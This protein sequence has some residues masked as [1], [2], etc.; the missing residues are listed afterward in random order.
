VNASLHHVLHEAV[1]EGDLHLLLLSL[2]L[3]A[4]HI[5]GGIHEGDVV[6]EVYDGLRLGDIFN[7]DVEVI[8]C[9]L[10]DVLGEGFEVLHGF[11]LFAAE[12]VLIEGSLQLFIECV[13]ILTFI[14]V[15]ILDLI[16]YLEADP[17]V[18]LLQFVLLSLLVVDL[19]LTLQQV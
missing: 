2:A 10:E 4:R 14:L 13:H 7:A 17:L 9:V 12:V 3:K 5:G 11:G 1:V 8:E 15:L 18:R 19:L 6:L 16:F